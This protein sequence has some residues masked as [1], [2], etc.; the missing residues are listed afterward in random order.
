MQQTSIVTPRQ[1]QEQPSPWTVVRP[2][3]LL[4]NPRQEDTSHSHEGQPRRA[5]WPLLRV[6][7]SPLLG[8]SLYR[9]HVQWHRRQHGWPA[10]N[11][12]KSNYPPLLMPTHL[13]PRAGGVPNNFCQSWRC[14]SDRSFCLC[15]SHCG[16]HSV[17][18]PTGHTHNHR[19]PGFGTEV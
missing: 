4:P 10:R 5:S 9:W 11:L 17:I 1:K 19:W 15:D 18:P 6:L 16:R 13:P 2:R 3:A 8:P 7:G 14:V 12:Q